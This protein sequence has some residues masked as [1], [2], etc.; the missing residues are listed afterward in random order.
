MVLHPLER[1]VLGMDPLHDQFRKVVAYAWRN[2]AGQQAF[3]NIKI[4]HELKAVL[5][6][7]FSI[8]NQIQKPL[9]CGESANR[10]CELFTGES[11]GD[12]MT[13]PDNVD[14]ADFNKVKK[15]LDE[16]AATTGYVIV[17]INISGGGAGHAYIWLSVSRKEGSPMDG[18]IYQTNVAIHMNS[19]FGLQ[20]W[21]NDA[22]SSRL[23]HLP[24]HLQELREKLCGIKS[25]DGPG[26]IP[27]RL[28]EDNYMLS[29]KHLR[30]DEAFDLYK[31]VRDRTQAKVKFVWSPVNMAVFREFFKT[32]RDAAMFGKI[33]V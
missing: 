2:L 14:L 1:K 18:Y 9:S 3:N 31:G 23:V 4:D 27:I 33:Q 13:N 12:I 32:I 24:F 20:Q 22:K 7:E 26:H 10:M 15:A 11:L 17:R 21:I 16:M 5:P 25:D 8:E 19:A 29:D 30:V 28:Y 6:E